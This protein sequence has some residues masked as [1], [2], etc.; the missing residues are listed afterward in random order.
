MSATANTSIRKPTDRQLEQLAV[1]RTE[2]LDMMPYMATLLFTLRPVDAP[3][4]GTFA[5]D[6]RLRMYIDFD[7]IARDPK[8]F[9]PR[10]CAESLLHECGH[11]FGMHGARAKDAG[12]GANEHGD[13]NLAG[14]LEINDDLEDAGCTT[15]S[16]DGIVPERLGFPDHE[17]AER[18]FEAIRARRRQ[19]QAK[20]PGSDG[21]PRRE[22]LSGPPQGNPTSPYRGCG[23]GSGAAPA[24]CELGDEDGSAVTGEAFAPGATD[25]E[26]SRVEIATA[27]AIR[28]HVAKGRGSVPGGLARHAEMVLAPP[29]VPWRQT[30]AA[31]VRRAVAVKL[32]DTDADMTRRSRRR[33]DARLADGRRVFYPGMVSPRPNIVVVRDTS[34]SMSSAD[35]QDVTNE[36]EGIARSAGVRGR[37][38][39]VVDVDSASYSVR[40][41]R[42]A[43]TMEQIT[44]GGGTNMGVGIDA[45]SKLRPAPS[46]IVVVTDGDTPWPV[47]PVGVPVVACIVGANGH[48]NLE[49]LPEWITGVAVDD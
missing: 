48:D 49:P 17:T 11:V 28:D 4:L 23:S 13:W 12:V 30:L 33:H 39:R 20:D 45:A 37:E 41:Y 22:Q 31:T 8:R 2:A 38:L 44:G 27:A 3:G 42:G 7:A 1:W 9:H 47:E 5:V 29:K 16:A 32:G 18:Y 21:Q 35:L 25:A 19:G 26:R 46:V 24:P 34:G 10:W 36:V 6:D 40:D 14:D 43:A 15:F